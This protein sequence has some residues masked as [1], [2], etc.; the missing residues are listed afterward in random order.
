MSQ[1]LVDRYNRDALAYRDL[2]A[3]VLRKAAVRLV[4]E[5][6]DLPAERVLDI[7]TG[8][9]FL[10]PDL[11]RAFPQA[12]ILGVDRSPGMLALAPRQFDLAIMDAEQPA[13][14]TGTFDLAVLAFMLF[15]LENPQGA[16]HEV[17][18]ILRPG[19]WMATITWAGDLE[20][21]ASRIWTE[22]LDAHGAA[23]QD[24]AA[25]SR[26]ENLNSPVKVSALLQSAGFR[27]VRAW[28]GGLEQP[29]DEQS[30]LLIKTSMGGSRLRFESLRPEAQSSCLAAASAAF[31]KLRPEEFISRCRVVYA[32]AH[33]AHA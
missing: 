15:H 16:L 28:T 23:P 31:Q 27:G 30:L 10:L 12:H 32:M 17:R 9:G 6:A 11:R 19:G 22:C 14:A 25:V 3:P 20:S 4:T 7:G 29:Y 13:L 26:H 5:L 33:T 18:R 2:W 8:V 21:P 24:P 1:E